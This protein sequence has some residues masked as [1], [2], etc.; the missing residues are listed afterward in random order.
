MGFIHNHYRGFL[1][2]IH[3]HCQG[4]LELPFSVTPVESRLITQLVQGLPVKVS[5]GQHRIGNIEDVR[6][7][8]IQ[9]LAKLA[10]G[11]GFAGAGI[12][13]KDAEGPRPR[14]V[15][16]PPQHLFTAFRFQQLIYRDIPGERGAGKAKE[17]LKCGH[18]DFSSSLRRKAPS[19]CFSLSLLWLANRRNSRDW[20]A[21]S[22]SSTGF[23]TLRLY[24]PILAGGTSF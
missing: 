13:G 19:C 23:F 5:G 10:D 21:F 14:H 18:Y 15:V 1:V 12:A 22:N 24:S 3:K 8:G 2:V 6:A 11:G 9:S 20:L 16:E 17:S 4:L 7:I